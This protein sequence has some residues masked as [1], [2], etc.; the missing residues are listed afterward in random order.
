MILRSA[1]DLDDGNWMTEAGALVGELRTRI[2]LV[3]GVRL[4]GSSSLKIVSH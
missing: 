4:R 2:R 3:S 1:D